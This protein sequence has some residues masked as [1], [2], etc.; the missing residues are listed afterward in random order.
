MK[1]SWITVDPTPS[2]RCTYKRQKKRGQRQKEG[3]VKIEAET[4]VM[5]LQT[6]DCQELSGA[7]RI[8]EEARN[9]SSLK[10]SEGARPC[11]HLDFSFLASRTVREH[12]YVILSQQVCGNLLWQ[13]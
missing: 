6:K 4:G 1:S 2:D 5:Q 13:P 7:T 9:D 12:I 3:H 10:S 8:Q 11:Q